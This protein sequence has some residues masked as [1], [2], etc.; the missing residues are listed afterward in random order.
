M[1]RSLDDTD[2]LDRR[3]RRLRKI[4]DN[5]GLVQLVH[6]ID[7]LVLHQRERCAVLNAFR[8]SAVCG[9]FG[10]IKPRYAVRDLLH[11]SG[12]DAPLG[13]M[14]FRVHRH[15][16]EERIKLLWASRPV[17]LRWLER[18]QLPVPPW[19]PKAEATEAIAKAEPPKDAA[20]LYKRRLAD[21]REEKNRDPKI[22]EDE[23]WRIREGISREDLRGERRRHL[24][25]K[26][27][28]RPRS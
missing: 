18:H 6:V 25:E 21:F 26:K 9:E 19:L 13:H 24:G 16:A 10:L 3:L 8:R 12:F 11:L 20:A 27:G 28:G 22:S 14:R 15:V 1:P 17:L 2:V 5:L 23:A 4:Q 7:W